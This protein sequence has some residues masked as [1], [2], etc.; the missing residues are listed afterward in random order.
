MA[1][2]AFAGPLRLDF[3]SAATEKDIANRRCEGPNQ[4]YQIQVSF[5]FKVLLQS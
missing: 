2:K 5:D 1:T 4:H 3:G